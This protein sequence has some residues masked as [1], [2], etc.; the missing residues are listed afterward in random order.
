VRPGDLINMGSSPHGV[1]LGMKPPLYLAAGDVTELDVIGL[2][3]QRQRV[4]GPW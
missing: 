4:I 1:G 2:R 3:T